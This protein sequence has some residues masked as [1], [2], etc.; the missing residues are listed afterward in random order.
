MRKSKPPFVVTL[1]I[2]SLFALLLAQGCSSDS[3]MEGEKTVEKEGKPATPS[4]GMATP[5][6]A[7]KV[8]SLAITDLSTSK[9]ISAER[10][11]ATKVE[12]VNW[13]DTSLG[14]PEPGMLYAQVITPGYRIIL[15]DGDTEYEYHSD[16]IAH[17]VLCQKG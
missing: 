11:K 5:T 15:S 2:L 12:E 17:I 14:C 16:A 13:P 3:R 6:G 7:E 10:I 4:S 1:A 9:G 8:T